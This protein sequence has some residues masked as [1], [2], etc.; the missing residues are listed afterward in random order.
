MNRPERV[1]GVT[2]APARSSVAAEAIATAPENG[3]DGEAFDEEGAPEWPDE[4]TESAMRAEQAERGESPATTPRRRKDDT[5][6]T[7]RGTL[8][9]LDVLVSRIPADVRG[10]LEELFRAKFTQVRRVPPAVLKGK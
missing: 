1:A 6:E 7:V 8:P 2:T 5:E 9:P 4:A 3:T 10:T